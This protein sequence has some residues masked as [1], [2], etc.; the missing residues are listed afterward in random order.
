M[1]INL[2][3]LILVKTEERI[4]IYIS[5]F[6]IHDHVRDK[7]PMEIRLPSYRI[8]RTAKN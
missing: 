3:L 5:L 6:D 1:H 2:A 7:I 8:R 4:K